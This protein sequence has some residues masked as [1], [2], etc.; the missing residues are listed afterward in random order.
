MDKIRNRGN[1]Q[2]KPIHVIIMAEDLSNAT[3]KKEE[4]K[5]NSKDVK[6]KDVIKNPKTTETKKNQE[7]AS[8][9]VPEKLEISG[10]PW[11]VLMYPSL[12][13]KSIANVEMQNKL[14]FMI[15]GRATRANIKDAVESAFN[16]KVAKV[17]VV[18]TTKGKRK[19]YI[20]LGLEHS[21]LDIATRLGMM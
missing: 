18:T 16:V 21:A 13:E 15:R 2:R 6:V 14:V 19:A 5:V 3:G 8:A 17:N 1:E 4:L 20:K 11:K 12:T 10:D 9:E 7:N